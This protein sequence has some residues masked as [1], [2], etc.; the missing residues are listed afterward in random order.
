MIDKNKLNVIYYLTNH[1]NFLCDYCCNKE[2]RESIK[3]EPTKDDI[4]NL[5][6]NLKKYNIGTFLI[7]GG[8]PTISKNL[9]HLIEEIQSKTNYEE[10]KIITNASNME[11]IKKLVENYDISKFYMYATIHLKYFDEDVLTT[12][13]Y[14]RDN[15]PKFTLAILLDKRYESKLFSIK[16]IIQ[17][18]FSENRVLYQIVRTSN[19]EWQETLGLK[20]TIWG[21]VKFFTSFCKE[22]NM[23]IKN[24]LDFKKVPAEWQNKNCCNNFIRINADGFLTN[25]QGC[26]FPPNRDP[27]NLY[28][29][30]EDYKFSFPIVKC[31]HTVHPYFMCEYCTHE[32]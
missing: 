12:L 10:I 16:N 18:E 21:D 1:C 4:S 8:E 26:C 19:S 14:I 2:L 17:T 27:S 20:Q 5:I 22:F 13:K 29:K 30:I 3:Y 9:F 15:F 32:D 28:D 6:D 31:T 24:L 25:Y 23:N 11:C 7:Y